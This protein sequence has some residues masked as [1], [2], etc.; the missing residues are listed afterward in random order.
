MGKYV[1]NQQKCC[2]QNIQKLLQTSNKKTNNSIR[3]GKDIHRHFIKDDIQIAN[4]HTKRCSTSLVIRESVNW[5]SGDI[6]LQSTKIPIIG[7]NMSEGN[8][9][10]L[11]MRLK[12]GCNKFWTLFGGY[13][14]I[15]YIICSTTLLL[16]IHFTEYMPKT[17]TKSP[18]PDGYTCLIDVNLIQFKGLW[19]IKNYKIMNVKLSTKMNI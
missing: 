7:Q 12:K 10:T 19:L 4:K 14:W 3:M 9:Q 1:G 11:T 17:W 6:A 16:S 13:S 15:E 5:N 18:Y 2:N 8:S